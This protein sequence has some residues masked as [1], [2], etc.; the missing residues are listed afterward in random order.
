MKPNRQPFLRIDL[1]EI[2]ADTP[3]DAFKGPAREG[4]T[5]AGNALP[6]SLR[7]LIRAYYQTV[8]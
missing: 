1:T 5:D 8:R 6:S 2:I 3:S 4:F 7:D